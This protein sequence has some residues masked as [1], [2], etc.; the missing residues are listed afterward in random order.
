[1]TPRRASRESDKEATRAR[2]ERDTTKRRQSDPN[3]TKEYRARR[4][5]R[6]RAE[7]HGARRMQRAEIRTRRWRA[8]REGRRSRSTR[9]LVKRS[10]GNK[11][12]RRQERHPPARENGAPRARHDLLDCGSENHRGPRYLASGRMPPALR[13]LAPCGTT[14]DMEAQL[15][16]RSSQLAQ[17]APRAI[18]IGGAPSSRLAA[19]LDEHCALNRGA[20]SVLLKRHT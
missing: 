3:T 8:E 18:R 15:A 5:V 12:K 10:G 19:E 2:Q 17:L 4:G 16:S 14:A 6:T 7:H 11:E 20:A 9:A 1:M 13:S